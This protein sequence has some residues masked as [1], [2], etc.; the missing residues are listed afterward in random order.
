MLSIVLLF[1]SF[2]N[3]TILIYSQDGSFSFNVVAL[4]V[5]VLVPQPEFIHC[6]FYLH[7]ISLY[8]HGT[9]S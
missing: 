9:M 2:R 1:K 5:P 7:N 4:G 8:A 3:D 6:N